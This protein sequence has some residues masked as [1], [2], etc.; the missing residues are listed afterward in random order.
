M[1]KV[2]CT[3]LWVM[4]MA[5]GG[6]AHATSVIFLNPGTSSETFWVS[7]SQFMQ[8]AA[9]DLGL[10]LR[11]RY[12]ERDPQNTLQQAR[13]ALQGPRRP[14]YLVLVNEQYI[15]PQILRLSQGSGVKLLIVNNALTVDQM[16]LLDAGK[17]P[18]W[19]GSIVADD[20]QAGYLML[21][22]MLRQHGPI[23]PGQSLDL[24]AFSGAKNTPVAQRREEGLRRALYE[25]PE[26]RLRQLVYGEWNRQRAFEQAT[27]MFKR[28]PQ[29]ALV[30]S[31]NDEMALGA[32]Q[33]LQ[34]SGRTPGKDVLFSAVNSSPQVLEARLDGRLS[35]LVAGHFT[36]GGWAMVLINDDA[37][38]VDISR[39][40]GRDREEALFQ[41]IDPDQAQRLQAIN[42]SQQYNV[43]FRALS[44]QGKP[45]S[46][47]Y[48]F[49]LQLLMH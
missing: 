33:A 47:R 3:C 29:T 14:D 31:A 39:Y 49:S 13:E 34:D 12:S 17:Y 10:D 28:Y 27:Q 4:G 5:F 16:Q 19:I 15:A 30:W 37:N 40:G 7:Y 8:A 45:E 18:N 38:G 25:H 20:Q 43:D 6:M 11:V 36:V 35:S 48:P 41:L 23:E 46:Y 42:A 9:K 44:A 24:L 2:L 32:M 22:N 21:K 1:L 26:V